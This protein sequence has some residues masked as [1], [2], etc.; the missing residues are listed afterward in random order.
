MKKNITK[1]QL[2]KRIEK[3]EASL[4]IKGEDEML[5]AGKCAEPEYVY[6]LYKE[7]YDLYI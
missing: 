1:K 6:P 5:T 2:L 7:Y 3:L 4:S